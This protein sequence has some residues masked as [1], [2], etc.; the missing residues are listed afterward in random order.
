M[1]SEGIDYAAVLADLEAKIASL[2][3]AATA[4]RQVMNLGADQG[5][6]SAVAERK[7]QPTEV[8]F[9]SFFGMSVPDAIRKFLNMMKRPQ[10]MSDIARAL[11]QGGL[12]TTSSN[13]MGVVG[14][15]LSRMRGAG[16]VVPIQGRW[17]LADW[18]PP[19]AR[20]RLEAHEKAKSKKV[21][22]R[23]KKRAKKPAQA[24]QQSKPSEEQIAKIKE[25]HAAGKKA[26]EIAKETGLHI[27]SITRILK[28]REPAPENTAAQG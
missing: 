12:P 18:Y 25:L 14:P 2:Q 26:G 16:D 24:A 23:T 13:L 15:T 17:A 28:A 8:S 9:D 6:A 1:A 7:D 22:K 4:I 5:I 19:G 10:T 20:E 21:K 27:F 3:S 11:Q